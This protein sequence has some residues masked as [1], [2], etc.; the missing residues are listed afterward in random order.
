MHPESSNAGRLLASRR[1]VA[2]VV[3]EECG[4]VFEATSRARYCSNACN[5]RAWRRR[6][7]TIATAPEQPLAPVE[8]TVIEPRGPIP[9]GYVPAFPSATEARLA[10]ADARAAL[11]SLQAAGVDGAPRTLARAQL[12][13]AGTALHD[14][15]GR[16]NIAAAESLASLR[17]ARDQ[18]A[19]TVDRS[20]GTNSGG[21]GH[22]L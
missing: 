18:L 14:A 8:K 9:A 15:L 10:I 1:R 12:V 11:A 22:R 16:Q 21:G 20:F 13:A 17:A 7:A 4:S 19:A 3:C 6:R 2:E 5:V